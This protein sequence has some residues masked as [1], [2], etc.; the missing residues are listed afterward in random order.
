MFNR[1]SDLKKKNELI[2]TKLKKKC[3]DFFLFSRSERPIIRNIQLSLISG[4]SIAPYYL[5]N[6]LPVVFSNKKCCKAIQSCLQD[7]FSGL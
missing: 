5:S 1:K 3:V 6:L 2:N 7:G 4:R